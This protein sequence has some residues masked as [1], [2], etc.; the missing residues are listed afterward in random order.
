MTLPTMPEFGLKHFKGTDHM[1]YTDDEINDL[2]DLNPNL[3][4][5]Q[6]SRMTGKSVDQLKRILMP[7]YYQSN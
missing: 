4:L 7:D 1:H 5:A 6:L 3:T 2:Y